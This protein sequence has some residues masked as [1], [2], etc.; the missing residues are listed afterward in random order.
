MDLYEQQSVQGSFVNVYIV[1]AKE[2]K[3]EAKAKKI[4]E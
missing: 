3:E 4:K 1:R 2:G